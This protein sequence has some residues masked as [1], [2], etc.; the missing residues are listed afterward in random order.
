MMLP[1]LLST[2]LYIPPA[3][4]DLVPR[5]RLIERLD[6]GIRRKLTLISAPAG[7][8][9]TTLLAAWVK[10]CSVP[11]AWVSLDAADSDSVRVLAYIIAALQTVDAVLGSAASAMLQSP[12][13]PPIDAVLTA[14]INDVTRR[15][16]DLMLILDDYHLIQSENVQQALVFLLDH[17][18][19]RI[20]LVIA[21][22]AD[23][24]LPLA[25]LRGHDQLVEVRQTDLVFTRDEAAAFLVQSAGLSLPAGDI[26][27]LAAHTEGWIAGL[28]MAALSM[29]GR[30]NASDLAQALEGGNRFI[31]DYLV[32]EV[33]QRQ[34]DDI[35][36]FLYRTAVLDRLSAPLCD[37][38]TGRSDGQ[39]TLDMLEHSDLF[40]V[41]LDNE[42]YW[43]RYHHLFA[44][45][46]RRRLHQTRPDA[47]A[48]LHR[49]AAD[50]YERHGL[51]SE[52][53][54]HV[55]AAADFEW[56]ADL[57]ERAAE[58]TLMRSEV[59][60]LLRWVD[61]LPDEL[62]RARPSLCVY[63]AWALLLAGRPL[64]AVKARLE[65]A[66]TGE[67]GS[68]PAEAAVFRA[69]AAAR[70][71]DARLSLAL[72]RQALDGLPEGKPFLRSV[73]AGS[74]GMAHVLSGDIEAA[75]QAFEESARVGQQIGNVIFAVGALSN[76]GGLCREQGQLRRAEAI[77]QRAL[78]F[79]TDEQ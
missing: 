32:E 63:H 65:D 14:L 29:K 56:A 40:I 51:P 42:R 74:L 25:Y 62:V 54:H 53:I 13:P 61:A 5:P 72:S 64:D 75:L 16:T 28:H 57:I 48:G 38:V 18:P 67:A 50:W 79:A 24:P 15:S 21:T 45:L 2:K 43:Y 31:L 20:H 60:T 41:S 9:K 26:D 8:G 30:Q 49:R 23:P 78:D 71:G 76:L 17:Q 59:A 11:V 46:L 73:A 27:R 35:Q 4:P 19:P 1:T 12:Q 7:F 39:A 47:V 77:Y 6:E 55:L 70:M 36:D 34:P 3:R 52:A 10:Q 37:A 69:L 22:R 33:L 68:L 58:Q 66:G 44:D